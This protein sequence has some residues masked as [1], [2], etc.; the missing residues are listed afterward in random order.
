MSGEHHDHHHDHGHDHAHP[1]APPPD[2]DGTLSHYQAMEL[3]VTALLIDK[4]VFSADDMRRQIEAMDARHAGLGGRLVA[5]AWL[6]PAFKDRALANGSAAALEIGLEIGPLKL[7]VVENTPAV[8]N[9]IVCTLCSCYP[10]MLLG[11][12]PDWYKSRAYRSRVVREPRAVLAEFGTRIPDDIE[13]RV[14]D[15]TADMRYLVLP[16]RPAGTED[17]DEARLAAL[18]TRDSMIGVALASSPN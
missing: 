9:V 2:A 10:R 12:P 4:N 18:A 7:I 13:L 6:D 8:H 16:R 3:A 5:R 11:L 1:H 15:S 14:H 17:W